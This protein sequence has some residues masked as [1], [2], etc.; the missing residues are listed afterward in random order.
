MTSFQGHFIVLVCKIVMVLLEKH[1][2]DLKYHHFD[3]TDADISKVFYHIKQCLIQ[4]FCNANLWNEN[5]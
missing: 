2:L 3:V 4:T 1:I 5:S